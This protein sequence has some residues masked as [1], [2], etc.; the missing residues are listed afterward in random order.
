[1]NK[2]DCN[3]I[4][5]LYDD[6]ETYIRTVCTVLTFRTHD[7]AEK[8]CLS[9]G[10]SLFMLE[11]PE[12]T[13][14]LLDLANTQYKAGEEYT[15]HV[16]G[17]TSEGCSVLYNGNGLFEVFSDL[18]NSRLPYYCQYTR[19]TDIIESCEFVKEDKFLPR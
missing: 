3:E 1:V 8:Y 9:Y 14:A 15:L 13:K 18:C 16:H 10:M 5:D 2:K 11:P 17:K 6:S 4:K 7:A 12:A 19:L